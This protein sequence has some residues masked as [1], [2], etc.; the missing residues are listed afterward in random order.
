MPK[1][2][3]SWKSILLLARLSFRRLVSVFEMVHERLL[4]FHIHNSDEK[5]VDLVFHINVMPLF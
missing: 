4:E 5:I 1:L 3:K 2:W